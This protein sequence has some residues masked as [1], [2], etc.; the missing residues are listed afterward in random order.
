MNLLAGFLY[1]YINRQISLI[2]VS[3][4]SGVFLAL[5]P[6]ATNLLQYYLFQSISSFGSAG[7]DSGNSPWII[8][9]WKERAPIFLSLQ[10]MSYGIG[11]IIA[12]LLVSPYVVGEIE[13]NKTEESVN[14]S[15]VSSTFVANNSTNH[16][17][18]IL[19]PNLT[20]DRRPKLILPFTVAGGLMLVSKFIGLIYSWFF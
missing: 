10:Q 14:P 13:F 9:M 8:E 5:Q 1:K 3:V 19:N 20:L 18:E 17:I 4:L 15:N 7:W 6:Q 12:P 2:V 16:T 11:T